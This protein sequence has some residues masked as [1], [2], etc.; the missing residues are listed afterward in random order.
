ML[1][2]FLRERRAQI[3]GVWETETRLAASTLGRERPA[4]LEDMPSL[5][6]DFAQILEGDD[7]CLDALAKTCAAKALEA[8]HPLSQVVRELGLFRRCVLRAWRGEDPSGSLADV[9]RATEAFDGVVERAVDAYVE[10]R[11]RALEVTPPVAL[12]ELRSPAAGRVAELD[13]VIEAIPCPVFLATSERVLSTNRAGLEALGV[14]SREELE[15]LSVPDVIERAQLGDASTGVPVPPERSAFIRALHGE[16]VEEDFLARDP[17]TGEQRYVH[18]V[19]GPVIVDSQTSGAVL[20]ITNITERKLAEDRFRIIFERV[21]MAMAQSDP[22][23]GKVV[24]ANAKLCELTGYALEEIVGHSF[25]EWTHPDDRAVNLEQYGQLTRGEVG[26]YA[27]EKRYVRKDGSERWVQVTASLL[28]SPGEPPRTLA[29][30]EDITA[31][32]R[33]ELEREELLAR[34]RAAGERLRIL[35]EITHSFSEARLDLDRL[36][37]V[38]PEELTKQIADAC[39]LYLVSEDRRSLEVVSCRH[40]DPAAEALLRTTLEPSTP[41]GEGPSGR[42]AATGQTVVIG[43][44]SPEELRK[45]TPPR[46][47]E[48]NARLGIRGLLCAPLRASGKVLGTLTVAR[49]VAA[50]KRAGPFSPED[51]LL[52]EELAD[53][54]ALAID[55]ARLLVREQVARSEAERAQDELRGTAEFRERLI[56]IVSHDLRTPLGAIV[57]GATFLARAEDLPDRLAKP[58]AR[59]GSA[60]DRMRR[61]IDQL[62]DFTRGRLGGGI[63]IDRHPTHVGAIVRRVLDELELSNPSRQLVLKASGWLEGE[64]DEMRLAQVVSNLVGNALENSP[65]DTPVTVSLA[66]QGESAVVLEVKNAGPPIPPELLPHLFDP[67]HRASTDRGTSGGLGLGLF[68][69]SEIVRAHGGTIRVASTAEE[70]TTLQVVLPRARASPAS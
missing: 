60:A 62:L 55:D 65:P 46:F 67:F 13:A 17:G 37:A 10:M 64:W 52:V 25:A 18:A 3:L 48:L 5:I 24:R 16:R 34:E 58:V 29:T 32:K 20:V 6:E 53:R 7:R 30:I 23:T 38:I 27:I 47:H 40:V 28:P 11:A 50:R 8:G 61:I 54:A 70:G 21:P 56:G 69:A 14:A 36:F 4:L 68:I 44:L 33:S 22:Q 31:R 1:G 43:D 63:P 42:A 49:H 19:A 51:R 9:E 66:D 45:V 41:M 12:H 39:V 26:V 59:L 35:A 57:M 2:P 15:R